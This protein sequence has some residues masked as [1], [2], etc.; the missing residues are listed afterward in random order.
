LPLQFLPFLHLM[1][2]F[3]LEI[4]LIDATPLQKDHIMRFK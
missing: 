3:L 1:T 2:D 4:N